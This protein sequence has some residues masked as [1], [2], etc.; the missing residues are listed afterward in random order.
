MFLSL[1]NFYLS[2]IQNDPQWIDQ[3]PE[4]GN[5]KSICTRLFGTMLDYIRDGNICRA[6]M[7]ADS[8][9]ILRFRLGYFSKFVPTFILC[10]DSQLVVRILNDP[11]VEK[12]EKSYRVFKRLHGYEGGKDFLSFESH[13]DPVYMRTRMLTYRT[14]MKRSQLKYHS[15]ACRAVDSILDSI[16]DSVCNTCDMFHKVA[17]TFITQLGF[18]ETNATLD[19]DLFESAVWLVENTVTHPER[20]FFPLLDKLPLPGNRMLWQKQKQLRDAIYG[21]INRKRRELEHD[22]ER[23]QVNEYTTDVVKELIKNPKNDDRLLLGILS[24]FFF[25]GFDTTAN[26]MTMVLYHFAKYPDVQEKARAEAIKHGRL[27]WNNV[28]D[29]EY[30]LAVINEVLR[31]YPTVPTFSRNIKSSSGLKGRQNEVSTFGINVNVFGLHR[32]KWERPNEF[33]PERWLKECK[34]S[35]TFI[36][37]ALGKRSC[38]GKQFAIVEMMTTLH[39]ILLRFRVTI[40]TA[41]RSKEPVFSEFGTLML[42]EASYMLSMQPIEVPEPKTESLIVPTDDRII[43]KLNGHL[44]D[45]SNIKH[46]GGQAIFDIFS[47]TV[48]DGSDWYNGFLHSERANLTLEKYR[49]FQ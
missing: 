38:L 48:K 10:K 20:V 34:E 42:D 6:H 35:H 17:I 43:I 40:P 1:Y 22:V 16:D 18:G 5:K 28:L 25:A 44:Y 13:H 11:H 45:I 7:N 26:T 39:K 46:P 9:N 30:L 41:L 8:P 29:M 32:E 23:N 19:R 24:V 27:E 15:V 36:P 49:I 3:L 37:F 14:L 4:A 12:P 21:L 47:G 33:L 31:L 2:Y